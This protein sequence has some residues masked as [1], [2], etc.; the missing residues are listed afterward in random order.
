MISQAKDQPTYLLSKDPEIRLWHCYFAYV[1]N[2]WII[3]VSKLVDKMK[4][5]N[6]ENENFNNNWFLS[7]S[8]IDDWN[9]S[10]PDIFNLAPPIKITESIKEFC[11]TCIES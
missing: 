9:E 6:A 5:S 11:D 8:E 10:E 2:A 7:D 4:L 1:S 3:Q